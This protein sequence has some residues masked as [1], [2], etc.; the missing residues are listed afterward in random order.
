MANEP[1]PYS[2]HYSKARKAVGNIAVDLVSA[3][4]TNMR[5]NIAIRDSV[6]AWHWTSLYGAE[7]DDLITV[8][9]YMKAVRDGEIDV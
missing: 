3:D 4:G 8:L 2:T 6:D 7:L 1:F 5:P 9:E